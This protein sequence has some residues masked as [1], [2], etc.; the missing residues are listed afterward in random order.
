MARSGS[1]AGI[2]KWRTRGMVHSKEQGTH[3][4][5][6]CCRLY[7]GA[8]IADSNGVSFHSWE[9]KDGR[10]VL[11]SSAVLRDLRARSIES[12][13]ALP[14]RGLEIGGLL[15]GQPGT[16]ELRIEGFEEVPCEHRYSPSFALSASDRKRVEELLAQRRG[17]TLRPIGF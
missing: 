13:L 8:R 10:R 7:S 3:N 5:G 9:S 1:W 16:A 14:R 17:D 6:H 4:S 11:F 15:F 2:A 12:F